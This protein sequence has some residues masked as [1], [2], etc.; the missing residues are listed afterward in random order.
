MIVL[1]RVEVAPAPL[2]RAHRSR[3]LVRRPPYVGTARVVGPATL[4]GEARDHGR[5]LGRREVVEDAVADR[6]RE[7]QVALV[8]EASE[9]PSGVG[10][11]PL[12]DVAP[13]LE[14]PEHAVE[15]SGEAL[16]PSADASFEALDLALL[17]AERR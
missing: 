7:E 12:L 14:Q 1:R 10:E 3:H 9:Q 16:A 8:R 15:L 6:L 4:V 13:R 11:G 5:D 2:D 17:A